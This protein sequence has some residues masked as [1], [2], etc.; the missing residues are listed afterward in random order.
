MLDKGII[1]PSSSIW[2][3]PVVLVCK[4]NNTYRFAVNY[5][6]LNKITLAISHPLPRLGCVFDTIGQ[7][8]A[9]IF[10]TLDLVSEF[11][12]IPMDHLTKHKAAFITHNGVYEWNRM[13]FGLR[14]APKTFQMVMRHVLRELNWKHIL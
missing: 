7:T 6:K 9:K 14:N 12:Q 5:R 13:P 8:N 4:K 1:E 2:N 10:S 11:W 3:S